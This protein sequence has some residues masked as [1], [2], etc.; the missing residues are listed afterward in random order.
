[1][2]VY[3]G[4]PRARL[5]SDSVFITATGDIKRRRDALVGRAAVCWLQG[6]SH[7]SQTYHVANALR[8]KLGMDLMEFQVVKHYPK[9]YLV[10]LANERLR[11]RATRQQY[12]EDEGRIFNFASWSE[13]R[14]AVDTN[15]EFRVNVRI[16]GIP[17]HAWGQDVAALILGRSCAIHYVE[18]HT[19]RQE[20]TRTYDLWAWSVDPCKIPKRVWLI[21]TDPN[22][23]QP[24]V[25]I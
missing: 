10:I 18:E 13:G 11:Q 4:D 17:P 6:N 23:E 2:A 14:E 20:R 12:L 24:P 16:E 19:C 15:L 9:Q 7:D 25:D 22:A 3:P 8:S 5:A 21:I 1:M